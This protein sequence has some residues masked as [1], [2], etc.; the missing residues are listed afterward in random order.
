MGYHVTVADRKYNVMMRARYLDDNYPRTLIWVHKSYMI[1]MR[2]DELICIEM[3]L[4]AVSPIHFTER[5]SKKTS[6][7]NWGYHGH[8][9]RTKQFD[10]VAWQANPKGPDN[11]GPWRMGYVMN[12]ISPMVRVMIPNGRLY[13]LNMTR[14][15]MFEDGRFQHMVRVNYGDFPGIEKV[16]KYMDEDWDYEVDRVLLERLKTPLNKEFV[17]D[18]L[19]LRKNP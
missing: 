1:P 3:N 2:I 13:I 17:K 5:E 19:F 9:H 18:I 15:V 8:P 14:V 12:E 4:N 6:W 16:D 7:W 10:V 11:G